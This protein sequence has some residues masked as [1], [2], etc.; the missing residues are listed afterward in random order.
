MRLEPA[1]SW[2][3][4]KHSTT[5]PPDMQIDD[6]AL[7]SISLADHGQLVKMLITLEPH[8][9]FAFILLSYTF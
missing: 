5:A 7:L 3:R 4:V 8:G 1:A 9:T 6:E 2:S